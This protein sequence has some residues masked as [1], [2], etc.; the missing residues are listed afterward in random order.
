[1]GREWSAFCLLMQTVVSLVIGLWC[2]GIIESDWILSICP[3]C[4]LSGPWNLN[5]LQ[6]TF[7]HLCSKYTLLD[8][9]AEVLNVVW[10]MCLFSFSYI[11]QQCLNLLC[12]SSFTCQRKPDILRIQ[13]F[14]I[15]LCTAKNG[16][17]SE[18]FFFL[19]FGIMHAKWFRKNVMR[20][21]SSLASA[22]T[23]IHKNFVSLNWLRGWPDYI[24]GVEPFINEFHMMGRILR[25]LVHWCPHCTDVCVWVWER[26]P[27]LVSQRVSVV[28]S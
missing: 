3:C 18:G 19:N 7:S 22:A 5:G 28:L 24:V 15:F 8:V 10:T 14:L 9:R 16:S 20:Q 25:I 11:T 17:A 1:M 27:V 2:E 6:R 13:A 23:F 4:L 12:M 26:E 21:R